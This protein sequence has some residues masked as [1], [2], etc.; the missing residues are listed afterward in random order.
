MSIAAPNPIAVLVYRGRRIESWHR[1]A[2]AIADPSGRLVHAEGEIQRSIYPRSAVKPLQALA[3]LESGAADQFA[4]GDAELALACASHSGEPRHV[5][6]VLAWLGRLGLDQGA[7]ECGAHAPMHGPSADRLRAYGQAFSPV[8]NNCS[9]KH[10]GMLTLA[11]ALGAPTSGYTHPDHPVQRRIK[12][13]LAEMAGAEMLPPPA[14]D[15][16]SVPTYPMPLAQMVIAMARLG[17]PSGLG[18]ARV[19]ACRRV[20][21]AMC[22][23]P[24]LVAGTGRPCTS[25]MTTVPNVIVKTGAE[26]VYGAALPDR[27]LGLALKVDDGAGRAAS[28]ALLALLDALQVLD[29][30]AK[31]ALLP[32]A[33]PRLHNHTGRPIGGLERAADWPDFVG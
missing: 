6:R 22:S 13:V 29:D 25:I 18:S 31:H 19:A 14:V 30:E 26:G 4:V 21:S 5:D 15:G 27:K 16:C 11:A 20:R 33:R 28:V 3:M 8:H 12:T 23:H 24:D 9:G 17:D 10:T 1:V 2:Y 32:L 7:L